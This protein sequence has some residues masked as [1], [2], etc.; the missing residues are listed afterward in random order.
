MSDGV[1]GYRLVRS[2]TGKH[3]LSPL[4]VPRVEAVK[5]DH[6][7]RLYR[8][9]MRRSFLQENFWP[10]LVQNP[11]YRKSP[12]NFWDTARNRNCIE[13]PRRKND[14]LEALAVYTASSV[15]PIQIWSASGIH[16]CSG[17]IGCKW[18]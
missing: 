2:D 11:L 8:L 12:P 18:Q 1:G 14:C 4:D 10:R 17:T 3:R 7:D 6:H 5:L 9:S 15:R 16:F 13:D